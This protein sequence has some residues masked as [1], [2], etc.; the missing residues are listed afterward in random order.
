MLTQE[1]HDNDFRKAWKDETTS[2]IIKA[3]IMK[4]NI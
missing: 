4:S 3:F 1:S 2:E